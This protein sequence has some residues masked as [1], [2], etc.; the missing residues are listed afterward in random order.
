MIVCV[1]Q[2][3]SNKP[4]KGTNTHLKP[5]AHQPTLRPGGS[6]AR[7]RFQPHSIRF[8]W[9]MV[10]ACLENAGRWMEAISER[11]SRQPKNGQSTT[12]NT[13]ECR[14]PTRCPR[15]LRWTMWV[16]GSEAAAWSLCCQLIFSI[17]HRSLQVQVASLAVK[18]LTRDPPQ[19]QGKLITTYQIF[20]LSPP[21]G[22]KDL[23]PPTTRSLSL[24]LRPCSEKSTDVWC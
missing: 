8:A 21:P 11:V 18:V 3:N 9:M 12:T 24:S 10:T 14:S 17:P 16:G 7:P 2:V 1:S 4:R 20:G 23:F 15:W 13:S 5:I 6:C 22:A 19:L